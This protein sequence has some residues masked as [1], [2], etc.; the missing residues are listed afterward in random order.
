MTAIYTTACYSFN[1]RFLPFQKQ[2]PKRV[3]IVSNCSC[4]LLIHV[5]IPSETEA[6]E[7]EGYLQLRGRQPRR[8]DLR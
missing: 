6:E 3:K 7:G 4:Y 8:A 2:K 5:S 1:A